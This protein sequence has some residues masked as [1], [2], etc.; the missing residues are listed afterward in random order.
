M[1]HLNVTSK[2]ILEELLNEMG[3]QSGKVGSSGSIDRGGKCIMAVHVEW[4]GNGLVSIAHYYEHNGDL[5]ADPEMVFWKGGFDEFYPVSFKQDGSFPVFQKAILFDVNDQ[6]KRYHKTYL[7][8]L[9]SFANEW[10][11]N[12]SFQQRIR[13]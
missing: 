13:P 4:V 9:V 7:N 6:P 12:I 1:M 3:L 10:L 8:K 5:C 2:K 11:K